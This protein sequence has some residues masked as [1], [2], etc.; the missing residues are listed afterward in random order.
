MLNKPRGYVTTMSDPEGRPTVMQIPARAPAR[1]STPSG[2]STSTPRACS[3]APT[4]AT[5][6][7]RSCT[8]S[9]RCAR[10]TTSSCRGWPAPSAA[11]WQKG[12]TLD[13][14]EQTA[15]AEVQHPRQHRQ[16]H[17]ARGQ[18]PRGQ[19]PADPSHGRGARLQRAQADPRRL[20]RPQLDGLRVG[21]TRELNARR[22]RQAASRRR[23]HQADVREGAQARAGKERTA[24]QVTRKRPSAAA[25]RRQLSPERWLTAD[26]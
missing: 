18:H 3:S 26:G 19:E 22:G 13:D 15:P 7:T 5:W 8:P 21:T 9:T 24:A 12:V 20:R 14:G 17:L 23:R 2:G 10:P 6:R 1:A 11:S 16:E 4:T 25:H